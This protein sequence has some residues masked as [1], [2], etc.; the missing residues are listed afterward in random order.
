MMKDLE[1]LPC[2]NQMDRKGLF[3]LEKN[4]TSVLVYI[5]ENYEALIGICQLLKSCSEAKD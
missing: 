2:V 4:I 1:L 3:N 5:Q